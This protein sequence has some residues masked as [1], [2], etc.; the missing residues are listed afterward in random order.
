MGWERR[1]AR[2]Y[3]YR[4]MRIDGRVV[5]EYLGHG[6]RAKRAAAAVGRRQERQGHKAEDREVAKGVALLQPLRESTPEPELH[7]QPEVSYLSEEI[8][9]E[10]VQEQIVRPSN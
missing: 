1:G 10:V 2:T 5:S 6:T 3:Y 7:Q 4:K 9:R 8:I